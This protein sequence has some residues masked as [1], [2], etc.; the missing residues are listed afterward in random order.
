MQIDVVEA[1]PGGVEADVL[2]FAV[3]DPVALTGA[4]EGLDRLVE[5]RLAQLVDAG[6]LRGEEGRVT[7]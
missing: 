7:L 4:A 3:Q 2:V 1:P 6:E 5:G